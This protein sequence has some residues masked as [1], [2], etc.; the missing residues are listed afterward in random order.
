M[1]EYPDF[2]VKELE[3][4]LIVKGYKVILAESAESAVDAVLG[5]VDIKDSVGVGG[6]VTLREINVIS[7]LKKRGSKVFDHWQEGASAS[8]KAQFRRE[9]V[10]ADVYLTSTN[11]VTFDGVFVNYDTFGNRVSAMIYGP[12]KV[13]I[14]AGYNKV[15]KNLEE[16][17]I[18][19]TGNT[20]PANAK[21]L[22]VDS[23]DKLLKVKSVIYS[24]PN[25][26]EITVVLIKGK[27]GI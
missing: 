17:E 24:C 20:A 11:A 8:E 18:R 14:M 16:A 4:K 12:K 2:N 19:I 15:V 27:Y 25:D 7:E 23:A 21:R 1:R 10:R 22:G 5:I 9:A 13:I 3:A 6:S 26:T